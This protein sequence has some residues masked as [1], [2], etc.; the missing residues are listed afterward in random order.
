MNENI[1]TRIALS[2]VPSIG[3]H[4][5]RLLLDR[6]DRPTD[7]FR[8]SRKDLLSINGIGKQVVSQLLDFNRWNEVDQIIRRTEALRCRLII[9]E[10]E[11]Y[12]ERLREISD[13][14]VLLW[15]RGDV[16]L[17]NNA[18]IA[19]VGTRSPSPYGKDIAGQFVRGLVEQGLTI[20]SG[21]AYGIDTIA[22]RKTLDCG[23]KTIAVLGS[24]I[25]RIYPLPN[26]PLA[27]RI[28]KEGGA[29][30]SE[31][32]PGTKPDYMNFP[33]R[34]RVVSGLSIGVLV[35]ETAREGG[36]MITARLA[37]DQNRE[38]FVIPHNLTSTRATGCHKLIRESSGK[39]VE[40]IEDI[41]SEFRWMEFQKDVEVSAVNVPDPEGVSDSALKCW[42]YIKEKGSCDADN[43]SRG[44]RLSVMGVMNALLELEMNGHVKQRPGRVFEIEAA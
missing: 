9:P 14:P 44:T 24:G 35:V 11:V 6:V 21:L 1:R 15:V 8:L 20:N 29:I 33:T 23:G 31:F 3:A 18:G 37:L 5:T 41:I 7:V 32:P 38:V 12:P 30:I 25:D 4:R 43:I 28:L 26:V 36:S 34:N 22:H 10:D 27:D 40:N 2:L 42:K 19:V 17:L 16:N 13:P 39:L